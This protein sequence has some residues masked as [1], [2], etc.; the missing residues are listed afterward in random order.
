MDVIQALSKTS[1]ESYAQLHTQ[2]ESRLKTTA[3]DNEA[4]AILLPLLA[5]PAL[6]PLGLATPVLAL[7]DHCQATSR[8]CLARR[9]SPAR[10]SLPGSDLTSSGAC[11]SIA[12]YSWLSSLVARPLVLSCLFLETSAQR[13]ILPICL[14]TPRP[15]S[16]C[17]CF[18]GGLAQLDHVPRSSTVNSDQQNLPDHIC[19]CIESEDTMEPSSLLSRCYIAIP[20]TS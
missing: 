20:S 17:C 12:H 2:T 4:L 8:H 19:T 15:P 1:K 11:V 16:R 6:L 10:R 3:S 14:L 18:P 13:A 9:R 5:D 7:L